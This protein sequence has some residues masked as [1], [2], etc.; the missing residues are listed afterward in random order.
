M[1]RTRRTR[2][3]DGFWAT[4]DAWADAVVEPSALQAWRRTRARL[5]AE[6]GPF[7]DVV[8]DLPSGLRPLRGAIGAAGTPVADD[9]AVRARLRTEGID[10]RRVTSARRYRWN[11]PAMTPVA[12]ELHTTEDEAVVE[13]WWEDVW[14]SW[15]TIRLGRQDDQRRP[16]RRTRATAEVVRLFAALDVEPLRPR[17]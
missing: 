15:P 8:D 3:V 4:V 14:A 5:D 9:D 6:C 1:S 13:A 16:D 2:P 7:L 10:H 17:D 11:G 12:V